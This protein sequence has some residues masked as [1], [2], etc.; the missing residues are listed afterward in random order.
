MADAGGIEDGGK[1]S[2]YGV[3]RT[4]AA[5]LAFV[6]KGHTVATAH[7]VEIGRGGDDG[8]A[9]L[10]ELAQHVPEFLARHGVYTGG[11]LVE[12]QHAGLV[13]KGARE[14]ELLLHAARKGT[15]TAVGEALYLAVDGLDGVVAVGHGGTEEGGEEVEVFPDGEVLVERELAGHIAHTATYRLHL[16]HHVVAVHTGLAGIGQEQGA[17]Y[18]HQRGLAG[19]VGAYQA[20]HL[21]GLHVEAHTVEGFHLAVRFRHAAHF[22]RFHL[23]LLFGV[24]Q[25]LL[26]RTCPS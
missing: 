20:E 5:H 24:T 6:Q 19:T 21:A 7:L 3:G 25:N 17:Q 23:V 2:Q 11:G 4:D 15:G 18:A 22:Y 16:G 13:H 26:S 8:D 14:G 10:A 1:L 12:H 9:A